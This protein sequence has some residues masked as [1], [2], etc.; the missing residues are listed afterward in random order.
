MIRN[1]LC[2]PD[3]AG[4]KRLN[5]NLSQRLLDVLGEEGCTSTL[6]NQ[7]APATF[8]SLIERQGFLEGLVTFF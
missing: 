7:G 5:V 6:T 4:L 2:S 8:L 3:F 1:K